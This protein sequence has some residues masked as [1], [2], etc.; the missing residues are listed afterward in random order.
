MTSLKQTTFPAFLLTLTQRHLKD[1]LY[2]QLN[3]W[4]NLYSAF[5]CSHFCSA[6]VSTNLLS[7][8]FNTIGFSIFKT[9]LPNRS[10]TRHP[11]RQFVSYTVS[12]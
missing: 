1:I 12:D 6:A 2:R 5:T 8:A 11:N 9:K 7:S 4:A 10:D 3:R